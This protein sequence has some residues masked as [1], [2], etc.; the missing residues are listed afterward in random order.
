LVT[1]AFDDGADSLFVDEPLFDGAFA[2][3]A[4]FWACAGVDWLLEAEFGAEG[5]VD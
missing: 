1:D 4:E 2:C 3:E 5:A